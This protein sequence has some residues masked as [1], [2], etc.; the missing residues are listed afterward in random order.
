MYQ[1]QGNER[2]LVVRLGAMGDVLHAL[3]AVELLHRA[4]PSTRVHWLVKPQWMPLLQGNP[5]IERLI[6]YRRTSFGELRTL[7]ADLKQQR[8]DLAVDLQGLM[9]SALIAS[10]SGAR[11]KVGYASSYARESL[12]ALAYHDKV[13]PDGSHITEHHLN[14]MRQLG[15]EGP[16]SPCW[17]PNGT[18]EGELP[19]GGFVL[20]SPFAGWLSKQW[21][22][23]FYPALA[24]RL[25][26]EFG[27]E[28]V[29]NVMPKERE[30]VQ[31][32]PKVRVHCSS[33][34][35]LIGATRRALAV[36]GLDSGPLHL[37]AALGKPGLALFGPTDPA[38]NGPWPV[39]GKAGQPGQI[40][41]LRSEGAAT[42]YGREKEIAASMRA[43]DPDLVFDALRAVLDETGRV[44]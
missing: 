12:A 41:V 23:E 6:P 25:Q 37:A 18:D 30:R 43:L 11:R 15:A 2:V 7:A 20:A 16:T 44:E 10:L 24:Q 36:L 34:S 39:A 17:L 13:R 31:G 38:R 33:I 32:L 14:L 26:Q 29:L 28:L 21:P 1:L 4:Y 40:R 8:Y 19:D 9:Q 35:G 42:S 22:L 5:H 27:I 3:P